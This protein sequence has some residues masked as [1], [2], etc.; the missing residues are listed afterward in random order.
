MASY[1]KATCASGVIQQAWRKSCKYKRRRFGEC[2]FCRERPVRLYCPSCKY[3]A[4]RGC[5]AAVHSVSVLRAHVPMPIETLLRQK[6]AAAV[7]C[8]FFVQHREKMKLQHRFGNDI[9]ARRAYGATL[10]QT[11]FRGFYTRCVPSH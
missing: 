9:K 10:L 8:A 6:K 5:S 7:I 2:A 3:R 4:C 1:R 11:L